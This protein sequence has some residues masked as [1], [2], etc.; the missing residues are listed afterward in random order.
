MYIGPN[1]WDERNQN[2]TFG[3]VEKNAQIIGH[4]VA[5]IRIKMLNTNRKTK[6]FYECM[7]TVCRVFNAIIWERSCACQNDEQNGKK[8]QKN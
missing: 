3:H 7:Q 2:I 4:Q 1:S 8:N 6:K 5:G